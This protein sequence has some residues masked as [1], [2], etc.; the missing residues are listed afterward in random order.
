MS[1]IWGLVNTEVFVSHIFVRRA[2]VLKRRNSILVFT[3]IE[4]SK[5]ARDFAVRCG[6]IRENDTLTLYIQIM[7]LSARSKVSNSSS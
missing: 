1:I 6:R 4:G 3:R 7:I 2:M 5:E